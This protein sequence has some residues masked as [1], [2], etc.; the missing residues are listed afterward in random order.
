MKYS[1]LEPFLKDK[2]SIGRITI[3]LLAFGYSYNDIC[4]MS[5]KELNL[6][7][8]KNLNIIPT[9]LVHEFKY[10]LNNLNGNRA[11]VYKSGRPYDVRRIRRIFTDTMTKTGY[12]ISLAKFTKLVK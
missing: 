11:F 10:Y 2:S 3:Y 5:S 9:E 7:Y 4:M 12:D 8:K 6:F 1:K